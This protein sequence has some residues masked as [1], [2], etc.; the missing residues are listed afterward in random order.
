MSNF[1]SD[2]LVYDYLKAFHVI[3]IVAWM[4]GLL[5]LPRLFVYH[6][7]IES[8]S[9]TSE[10][11]K[12]MEGRLYRYIMNP[13]MMAAWVLG[14]TLLWANPTLLERGWMHVKLTSII[15]LTVVHVI[16]K[17]FLKRFSAD[18]N[19]KSPTYYRIWNEVPTVLLI[20]IVVMAVV[21]PF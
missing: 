5:Y 20:I 18:K 7:D 19:E 10:T 1:I 4:A 3:A 14:L 6:A 8:G 13:A 17:N 2:P 16:Y 12:I 15:I 11:F 9:K 21:E